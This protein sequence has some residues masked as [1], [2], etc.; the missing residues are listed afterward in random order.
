VESNLGIRII[1][2]DEPGLKLCP[3]SGKI[4]GQK[5]KMKNFYK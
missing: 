3:K 4:L 1:N 2:S 5:Q